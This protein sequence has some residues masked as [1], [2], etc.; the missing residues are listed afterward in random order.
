[1]ADREEVHQCHH[2]SPNPSP[3]ADHRRSKA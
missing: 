3:P 2:H 1:M